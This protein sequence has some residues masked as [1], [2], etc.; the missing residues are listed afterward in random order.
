M[1][2]V[3]R[4]FPPCLLV[5]LVCFAAAMPSGAAEVAIQASARSVKAY[6]RIEFT[7]RADVVAAN[8][9][10]PGDIDLR[11]EFTGPDGTRVTVPAFWF[12]PFEYARHRQGG[13]TADWIYPVGE[14]VWKAR[15]ATGTP[16]R[17]TAAARLKAGDA[18][19]AS[20]PV[21]FTV[22]PA[23]G[24]GYV[25]VSAEDPRF[26]A[27][28][29]GAPLFA[30]GQNVAF[31]KDTERQSA[32]IRSL[33]EHGANFARVWA[34][35]EDWGMAVEARK[36][37]WSR[38][39]GWKPPT[40][41]KPGRAGYHRPCGGIERDMAEGKPLAFSPTRPLAVR[42]GTAYVLTGSARAEPQAGLLIGVS[43][44][45]S[46]P[47]RC[48]KQWRAFTHT[49]RTDARR[50][51]LG[52]MTFRTD[53][54]CRLYLKDLSLREADGGPNLLWEADITRPP[55]GVYNQADAFVLDRIVETAETAG[56]YLQLVM[57]TRDHYMH[58]LQKDPSPEYARAVAMAKRLVR[59]FVARWGYSTHVAAWEYFNEMNPGLPLERFYAEVGAHLETIDPWRHLRATSNWHSPSKWYRHPALD[60]ADM[61]YYM[62][63]TT[64]DLYRDAVASV[65]KQAR[66]FREA[67]PEKPAVFSEFGMT[68]DTW[69]RPEAIDRD[70]NFLHLH[71][72]LWTSALSGLAG[73][74]C[75]WYWDDIHKRNLYRLYKPVA[76]F[77]ADVPYTTAGL[78]PTDGTVSPS[79]VRVVGLQGKRHA[80]LWLSD[81]TSTWWH[82]AKMG[83]RPDEVRGAAVKVPNLVDGT[84]RVRWW[85]TRTGTIVRETRARTA[86]GSLAAE[87]PPFTGDVAVKIEPPGAERP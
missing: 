14:P 70:K 4:T 67:A 40:A 54:R 27:F 81:T 10:D 33:G 17:W 63:P 41:D 31:I 64:G 80:Y 35:C 7:L 83:R 50:R 68:T 71:N 86:G 77:V 25:R 42:P 66:V 57:C 56:V 30:V 58:L 61:H 85:D 74:V 15:F 39:W 60:T 36:S 75:H 65:V 73:T 82:V 55:L 12:Q 8:P 32:M 23:P 44:G 22:A 1:T 29:D 84:Y 52:G 53:G 49:F 87:A 5:T 9:Y 21:A 6:Q 11:V 20:R 37:G 62:R 38:S 28:E 48:G 2:R 18:S 79:G 24:R 26:L 45:T 46:E 19:A 72:A 3:P 59:Y 78:R 69:G 76:A 13:G 51:F 47:I 43:G 16:G 34:C